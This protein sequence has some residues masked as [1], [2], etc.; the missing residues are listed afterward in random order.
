MKM[1][2]REIVKDEEGYRVMEYRCEYCGTLFRR[3]IDKVIYLHDGAK[4][5]KKK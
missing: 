5:G 4:E 2:E 1:V 3:R